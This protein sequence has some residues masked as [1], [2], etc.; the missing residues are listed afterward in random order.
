MRFLTNEILLYSTDRGHHASHVSQV[1]SGARVEHLRI[2][3]QQGM[4]PKDPD[5]HPP[6]A[7]ALLSKMRPW[8]NDLIGTCPDG[9]RKFAH[10]VPQHRPAQLSGDQPLDILEYHHVRRPTILRRC[11]RQDANDQV[12]VR[13]G[14]VPSLC[15]RH[16][17]IHVGSAVRCAWP[18]YDEYVSP[19]RE[20]IQPTRKLPNPGRRIHNFQG[21][22]AHAIDFCSNHQVRLPTQVAHRLPYR[23][24]T[25][26]DHTCAS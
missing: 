21:L 3:L 12:G 24:K 14:P 8:A 7:A 16:T 18:G 19:I 15:Q 22:P 13:P 6:G 2:G 25:C 11:L 20:G 17:S 4:R 1:R 26:V 23:Q 10:Q 5:C 9:R